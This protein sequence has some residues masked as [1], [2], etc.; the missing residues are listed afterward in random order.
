MEADLDRKSTL[1]LD[2]SSPTNFEIKSYQK[3]QKNLSAFTFNGIT[4]PT[5]PIKVQHLK[6]KKIPT[7]SED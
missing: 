7:G 6:I 1:K 5:A 3:A 4:T 2:T